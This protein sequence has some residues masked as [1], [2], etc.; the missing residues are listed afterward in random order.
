MVVIESEKTE[1]EVEAHGRAA[2]C[3]TSTWRPTRRC[4]AGRCSARSPPTADEPFDA[5]AFAAPG[6]DRPGGRGRVPAA[7]AARPP[8]RRPPVA[9]AVRGAPLRSPPRR[10]PS[11]AQLG[12]D[13]EPCPGSGPGGRVTREDVEALAA[14]EP[15]PGARR[16]AASAWRCRS[17]GAG[18]GGA[19]A[20]RLRYRRLGLRAAGGGARRTLARLRRQPARRRRLGR[21]G[22]RVL[23]RRERRGRCGVA[24]G[25][26]AHIV[27]A[28]LGAAVAIEVALSRPDA[29]RSLTL[30]RLSSPPGAL[31]R[32]ARGVVPRGRGPPD[33]L[34]RVL[35]PW[36]FSEAFL[37]DVRGASAPAAG[38]RRASRASRRPRWSAQ[39]PGSAPGPA[40]EPLSSRR[41]R[42][43]LWSSR[44]ARTCSRRTARRSVRALHGPVHTSFRT[45]AT[46]SRSRRRRPSVR[47]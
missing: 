21:A 44:P 3:D 9:G 7:S 14:A 6:H 15:T 35:L 28:S 39:P 40:R 13:L 5:D 31:A 43:R 45:P 38:W 47:S 2:C 16:P 25:G 41:S 27:G 20:A 46:R 22:A 18:R 4:P 37:A 1:A 17:H 32:G 12:V 26:A 23:R 10:A 34:A 8:A 24:A 33:T 42:P 29:V 19:A 30:S 36:L 11:R